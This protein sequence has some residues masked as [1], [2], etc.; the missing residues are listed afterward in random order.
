MV[1]VLGLKA[2]P[3]KIFAPAFLAALAISIT[4]SSLSTEQGPAIKARLSPPTLPRLHQRLYHQDEM[5]G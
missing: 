4:C 3:L 2:P 5:H 1:K